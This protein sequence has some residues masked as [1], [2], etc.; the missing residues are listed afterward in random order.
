[1]SGK[2]TLLATGL[3]L[4]LVLTAGCAMFT[5]SITDTPE[6]TPSATPTATPTPTATATPTPTATPTATPR[7]TPTATQTPTATPSARENWQQLLESHRQTLESAE[8]WRAVLSYQ[9]GGDKVARVNG[10]RNTTIGVFIEGAERRRIVQIEGN[11]TD[12]YTAGADSPTYTRMNE[13]G[14][15]S[16]V[17]DDREIRGTEF[18]QPPFSAQFLAGWDYTEET[19]R[20]D[21]G[22]RLKLSAEGVERMSQRNRDNVNGEVQSVSITV[23]VDEERGL[24]DRLD[25]RIAV[26]RD[27]GTV[28]AGFVFRIGDVGSYEVSQPPWTD[29]ARNRTG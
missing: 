27:G 7:P 19:V 14:A 1:M 12:R 11:R 23:Y 13:S 2:S 5:E 3:V 4:A 29:E 25:Y 17:R 9:F 24:I 21:R 28:A 8:N 15:I 26:K 22:E 6:P 16:Y 18:L 20:T 10:E